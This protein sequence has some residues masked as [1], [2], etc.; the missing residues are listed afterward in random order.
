MEVTRRGMF[1]W[2]TAIV[3]TPKTRASDKTI[4]ALKTDAERLYDYAASTVLK[5]VALRPKAPWI[6]VADH[7]YKRRRQTGP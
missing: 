6:Q 7:P 2:L 3:V 4:A 1:G 5:Q